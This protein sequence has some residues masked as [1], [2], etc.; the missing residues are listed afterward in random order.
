MIGGFANII[1]TGVV[2]LVMFAYVEVSGG[3]SDLGLISSIFFTIISAL[4]LGS[5]ARFDLNKSSAKLTLL[6]TVL[7][8]V[9]SS[10]FSV[11]IARNI[12]EFVLFFLILLGPGLIFFMP[13]S[14]LQI[15]GL[16][17]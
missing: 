14:Y 6:C 7:L 9:N 1:W 15:K 12:T 5:S 16:K 10:L 17:K 11:M 8:I 4:A 2:F 13:A 3:S